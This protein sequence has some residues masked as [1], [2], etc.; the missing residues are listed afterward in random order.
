MA[1]PEVIA[2]KATPFDI[3]DIA[4]LKRVY[5]DDWKNAA[6]HFGL[7]D[8]NSPEEEIQDESELV[9]ALEVTPKPISDS[10]NPQAPIPKPIADSVNPQEATPKPIT[11][12]VNPQEATP[13]NFRDRLKPRAVRRGGQSGCR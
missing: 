5:R 1:N 4:Y 7:I 9:T 2:P 12:S 8:P 3:P 10:G 13:P 11:D 6:I